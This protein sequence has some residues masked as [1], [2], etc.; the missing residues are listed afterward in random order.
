M[1]KLLKAFTTLGIVGIVIA[2]LLISGA[3]RIGVGVIRGM[4]SA[5]DTVIS[6]TE[7][8]VN[9]ADFIV[10]DGENVR[11]GDAIVIDGGN[12]RIGGSAVDFSEIGEAI[13]QSLSELG[14]VVESGS[15]GSFAAVG[16]V[17]EAGFVQKRYAFSA[18]TNRALDLNLTGCDVVIAGGDTDKI[19]VDVLESDDFAYDFSTSDSTLRISD[20]A[21]RS[22]KKALLGLDFLLPQKSPVYTGLAMIV[23]LPAEFSGEI[24][25]ITS[26]GDVKIGALSLSEELTIA[27]TAGDVELYDISA[28]E[29]RASTSDGEM[30]LANLTA[31]EISAVTTNDGITMSAL[32]SKRLS[33]STTMANIE[34]TRLFGEKFEFTTANGHIDGSLIGSQSVFDIVTETDGSASPATKENS[35]AQYSL[36]AYTTGGDINVRF[37]D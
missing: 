20:A 34:F 37:V 33:A 25:L 19:V 11:I 32:T 21:A 9:I 22:R 23:Y 2:A 17:S 13:G 35:R 8:G 30:T 29:I 36:R 4:I 18:E 12:I 1:R 10:V 26:G 24:S 5:A 16:D 3:V 15:S 14:T 7:H 27:T 6:V 28:D 31:S